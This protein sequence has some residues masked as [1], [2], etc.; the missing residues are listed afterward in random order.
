[1]LQ[2]YD[3]F[4]SDE[5]LSR[6]QIRG[7]RLSDKSILTV[8]TAKDGGGVAQIL[9]TLIP[10]LRDVGVDIDW[11]VID[12]PES[13]FDVT[14]QFHNGLQGEEINLSEQQKHRYQDVNST[15]WEGLEEKYDF[16]LVQDPQPCALIRHIDSAPAVL[17]L[18]MDL[19]Q[20]DS[21]T[22]A[23]LQPFISS[24][25]ETIVSKATYYHDDLNIPYRVIP[26]ATDP[27][28]AI[29]QPMKEE[30][31]ASLVRE[32]VGQT[33]HLISQVSR[34]DKWKDP[35]G[36]I[37]VFEK[38]HSEKECSLILLG[39]DADDDPEGQM[40]YEKTLKRAKQ[41][42]YQEDITVIMENNA[43]LVN[44]VQRHSDVVLQKSLR[45]GFGLTVSEAML[46]ATAVA[47][48]DVGGI[49][50]QIEHGKTGF[51]HEPRNHDAFANTITNLLDDEEMKTLVGERAATHVKN[52]FLMTRLL[53]QYLS[54]FED[55]LLN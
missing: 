12:A 37:N 43:S 48:S 49:P 54:L 19:S 26:P 45:E 13:F 14:K 32:R 53:D 15:F 55:Y 17:R 18:H 44:A 20:P 28:T 10:M 50:R 27:F 40:I 52:N 39:S 9:K 33:Q 6:L 42:P 23:Y 34:F 2:Q 51:L 31:A 24:Y 22:W 8:N 11:K 3:R 29:N 47:A 36:V 1:M 7:E 38:V 21:T 41:S 35:Q 46:K 16:Y 30:E 25:D 4:L 5:E